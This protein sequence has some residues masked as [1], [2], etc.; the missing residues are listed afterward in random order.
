[1]TNSNTLSKVAIS[2]SLALMAVVIYTN[3]SLGQRVDAVDS[4]T[5]TVLTIVTDT[6]VEM[7]ERVNSVDR[8]LDRIENDVEGLKAHIGVV[9]QNVEDLKKSRINS[10]KVVKKRDLQFSVSHSPPCQ[11]YWIA[12]AA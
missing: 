1:M 12:I 2:T 10:Y 9:Q 5:D 6:K 3:L 11:H 8:R 4:R 7:V